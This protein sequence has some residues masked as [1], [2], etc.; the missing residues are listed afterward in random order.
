M[1]NFFTIVL[2]GEPWIE[3]HFPVFESLPVPWRWIIVE[4]VANNVNCTHWCAKEKPRLSR[5]GTERYLSSLVRTDSITLLQRPFWIGGK[6]EMCNAAL[7][8]MNEP[9]LLWQVDADEVWRSEQIKSV[10]KLFEDRPE[11]NCAWFWC[12]YFVGPDIVTLRPDPWSNNPAFEW[13]RVWRFE[14]GMKFKRHEP[15]ELD[16]FSEKPITHAETESVG[17]V[18]DHFSYATLEQVA[19]KSRYYAGDHNPHGGEYRRSVEGWKRLQA[20]KGPWPVK[21]KNYLAFVSDETLAT[22]V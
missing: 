13:K 16:G 14:P 21:L 17:A 11:R 1:I 22:K 8:Q 6:V 20:H 15:P 7:E 12:R 2:D 4:G 19:F 5:D 9:G 10:V 3:R 18:F